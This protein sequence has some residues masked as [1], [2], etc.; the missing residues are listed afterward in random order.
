[1]EVWVLRLQAVH[2][3]RRVQAF[4]RAQPPAHSEGV[5]WSGEDARRASTPT[6]HCESRCTVQTV[7]IGVHG[8]P[9]DHRLP[10]T[11]MFKIPRS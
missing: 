10:T 1:M 8:L 3:A 4:Q 9:N 7:H 5:V 11:V 2:Q 6:T